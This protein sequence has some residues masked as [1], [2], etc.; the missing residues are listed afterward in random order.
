MF[1]SDTQ[2]LIQEI[3]S[4][5]TESSL[6]GK[7]FANDTLFSNLQK[8]TIHHPMY[9]ETIAT[10][11]QLNF[12]ALATAL[13]VCQSAIKSNPA[14]KVD[15]C[16]AGARIT[17]SDDQDESAKADKKDE[18]DEKDDGCTSH[19]HL[20]KNLLKACIHGWKQGSG[21]NGYRRCKHI[22]KLWRCFSSQCIIHLANGMLLKIAKDHEWG[23]LEFQG[24]TWQENAMIMTMSLFGGVGDELEQI[25]SNTGASKQQLWH[26]CLGHPGQ[27]KTRAIINKLKG[28]HVVELD[29]EMAPTCEHC[30]QSK[31]TIA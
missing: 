4:I 16:Q 5:Q 6:L 20:P 3:R 29:P 26:E 10:I 8:C 11:S 15:P 17:G 22:N 30:I 18:K 19:T 12:N 28:N 24:K 31:S 13:I 23:L 2:K 25:K 9:K 14:Y 21:G 1:N 7:L 27:D